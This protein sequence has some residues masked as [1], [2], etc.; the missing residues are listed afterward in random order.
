MKLILITVYSVLLTGMAQGNDVVT[1]IIDRSTSTEVEAISEKLQ[2]MKIT[3]DVLFNAR[4][5][6]GIEMRSRLPH[7]EPWIKEK[8]ESEYN[9]NIG[10]A[11]QLL[12][13]VGELLRISYAGCKGYSCQVAVSKVHSRYQDMIYASARVSN[14]F[15]RTTLR[16]LK[17]HKYAQRNINKQRASKALRWVQ[18]CAPLADKLVVAST[19]MVKQSDL[20]KN[21]TEGAFL[22]TQRN[23]VQNTGEIRKTKERNNKLSARIDMINK[24]LEE[25]L[26]QERQQ[27]Q[28]VNEMEN[29]LQEHEKEYE[30]VKGRKVKTNEICKTDVVEGFGIPGVFSTGQRVIRTC[31]NELDK[32]DVELKKGE[33]GDVVLKINQLRVNQLALLKM[34]N[35]IQK[36]MTS[37]YGELAAS[38]KGLGHTVE[39]GNDLLRAQHALQMAIDTLGI[40]KTIFLNNRHYW[41]QVTDNAQQQGSSGDTSVVLKELDEEEIQEFVELLMESGFNWLALGKVSRDAMVSMIQVKADVDRTFINLPSHDQAKQIIENSQGIIDE[42]KRLIENLAKVN[43]VTEQEIEEAT[44]ALQGGGDDNTDESE[45][46]ED[47][48]PDNYEEDDLEL[49]I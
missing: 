11:F 44:E 40:V 35:A 38:V 13:N 30:K 36:N 4:N 18:R 48:D 9:I 1:W 19:K 28:L 12:G 43:E 8:I 23:D 2:D 6:K 33:M 42:T 27:K 37:L 15:V 20:L 17:Y 25:L 32:G 39:L 24:M 21:M 3:P 34:K 7:L 5:A 16:A 41:I 22:E 46:D 14:F 10:V 29:E 31:H 45:E 49:E 26:K 47:E